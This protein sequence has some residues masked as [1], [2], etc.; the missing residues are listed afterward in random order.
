VESCHW[1]S[2]D[3]IRFDGGQANLYVYVAGEPVNAVDATGTG[4]G[5]AGPSGGDGGQCRVY[6][7]CHPK[8]IDA[9]CSKEADDA[10][11]YCKVIY[12]PSYCAQERQRVYYDCTA[13]ETARCVGGH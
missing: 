3:P 5:A 1:T 13:R 2:K 7:H 9:T 6:D 4:G 8:A 12:V 10:Y 11:D